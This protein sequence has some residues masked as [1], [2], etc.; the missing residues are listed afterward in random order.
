MWMASQMD[1]TYG[2]SQNAYFSQPSSALPSRSNS[3]IQTHSRPNMAAYARQPIQTPNNNTMQARQAPYQQQPTQGGAVAEPEIPAPTIT[4][5]TPAE[6]SVAGGTEVSLFGY[7]FVS[8]DTVMFGDT[9]AATMFWGPQALLATAPP[10]RPGGVNVSLERL[11]ARQ[12][13]QYTQPMGGRQIFTYTEYQQEPKVM[14]MALKHYT[15]SIGNP[16]PWP[17]IAQQMATEYQQQIQ[18]QYSGPFR[19]QTTYGANG[20]A[21]NMNG[22]FRDPGGYGGTNGGGA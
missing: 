13:N 17:Q 15:Q 8:G 9:R 18:Q 20:G 21:G 6:G 2:R 14:E 12:N 1:Q 11:H 22:Q 7:N 3:P 10:S 16:G 5:I 19:D 4:K